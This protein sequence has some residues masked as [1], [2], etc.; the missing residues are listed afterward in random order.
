M[1]IIKVL[2]IYPNLIY[3]ILI[4]FFLINTNRI[5]FTIILDKSIKAMVFTAKIILY[6]CSH[7][8]RFKLMNHLPNM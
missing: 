1:K 6:I 5:K 3:L 7:L 2:N 4:N 8:D